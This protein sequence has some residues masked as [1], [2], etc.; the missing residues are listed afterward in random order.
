M[1][2]TRRL[3]ELS[4]IFILAG[5]LVLAVGGFAGRVTAANAWEPFPGL[6]AP[7]SEP[8]PA[9]TGK[10]IYLTFDDGPSK[11]TRAILDMLREEQAKAT[12]FVTAQ[13]ED[14]AF[15]EAMLVRMREEGHT[16]GLH[17]YTHSFSQIYKYTDAFLADLDK[18]NTFIENATGLRPQILRF[19]G[20]SRSSGAP[21]WLL[22]EAKS[23]LTRRGYLYYDW[24]VV[25]GDDT[26]VVY[27]ADVLC[28]NMLLRL[29]GKEQAI[30]LC[31]DNATPK[32]TPEAVRLL[33][34][35]LRDEGYSFEALTPAVEP[36]HIH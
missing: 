14:T 26:A 20:G 32:T 21:T 18:L 8:E 33:I 6:Y 13:Y 10:V 35:A 12:F 30:I 9:P 31:H 19:P 24:D 34:R 29:K 1:K 23:E 28:E 15:V 4:A 36:V 2:Q 3:A 27:P 22:E 5:C 11:N 17:S 16:I 7:A 25:S